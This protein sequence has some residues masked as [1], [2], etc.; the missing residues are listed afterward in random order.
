[1]AAAGGGGKPDRGEHA[2]RVRGRGGKGTAVRA[3]GG[4]RRMFCGAVAAGGSDGPVPSGNREARGGV[5]SAGSGA[6]LR[7]GVA[8]VLYG[9]LGDLGVDVWMG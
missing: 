7:G 6:V 4:V 5:V 2:G 8:G 9:V 1:M 3:G